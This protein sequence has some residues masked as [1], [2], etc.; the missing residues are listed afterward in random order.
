MIAVRKGT[1]GAKAAS[2]QNGRAVTN[3]SDAQLLPFAPAQ[4]PRR[5]A[6][7]ATPCGFFYG[8]PGA[9]FPSL[10]L[11]RPPVV[12]L[13][14]HPPGGRNCRRQP[15]NDPFRGSIPQGA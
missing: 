6:K 15:V 14:D 11:G 13:F 7:K 8:V 10:A 9:D 3:S 12:H 1:V 4:L 5:K 2:L